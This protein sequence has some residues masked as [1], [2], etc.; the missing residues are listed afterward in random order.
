MGGKEEK[1][2]KRA[3][4]RALAKRKDRISDS[5]SSAKS[6]TAKMAKVSE[7]ESIQSSEEEY[8]SDT[9]S[10]SESISDILKDLRLSVKQQQKT[11]KQLGEKQDKLGR[12]F[13][14]K[15][16]EMEKQLN[17]LEEGFEIK[18]NEHSESIRNVHGDV[19]K[20]KTEQVKLQEAYEKTAT[21]LRSVQEKV[22]DLERHSR[23]YNLRLVGVPES[24]GEDTE[25][26]VQGVNLKNHSA[27]KRACLGRSS[28]GQQ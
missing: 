12:K 28:V 6:L 15:M 23:K 11:M 3:E 17:H 24:E 25:Q 4:A 1:K 14:T 18:F 16:T 27:S 2:K 10:E 13:D 7:H 8:D 5:S 20:V 19:T 9:D 26:L 22:N 21:T